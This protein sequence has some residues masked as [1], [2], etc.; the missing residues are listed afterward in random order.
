MAQGVTIKTLTNNEVRSIKYVYWAFILFWE[1][2]CILFP[3]LLLGLFTL[4][5]LIGVSSSYNKN[6]CCLSV[7]NAIVLGRGSGRALV[8][9]IPQKQGISLI[10]EER[11]PQ[12]S[13]APW[14]ECLKQPYL[15]HI[16]SCL[17]L[18]L[19][20]SLCLPLQRPIMLK[21]LDTVRTGS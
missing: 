11:L 7:I 18:S 17:N 9:N 19:V 14:P 13:L 1:L 8:N 5:L 16:G 6:A 10:L 20:R 2:L 15:K 12:S 4:S 3:H 21:R